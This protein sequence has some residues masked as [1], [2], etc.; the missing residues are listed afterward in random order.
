MRGAA[1]AIPAGMKT[2]AVVLAVVAAGCSTDTDPWFGI[3][4]HVS[5]PNVTHV[6]AS[7]PSHRAIQKVATR[8][9]ANGNF[10]FDLDP[11]YAWVVSFVDANQVG[12][13]MLVGSLQIGSLDALV[14]RG[15]GSLDLG[16]VTVGRGR[17]RSTTAWADVIA[18]LGI[19]DAT[20][21]R[22][23]AAD[24]LA[25]RYANPD[26]DNDGTIDALERDADFRVDLFG[27][28][29]LT[30]DG[31]DATLDDLV[32]APSGAVGVH[33]LQTGIVVSIPR[34]YGADLTSARMTFDGDF[35]GTSLGD[36]TPVVPAGTPVTQPEVLLGNVDGYP[37]IGV[38]ARAGHDLPTGTY[39]V[40]TTHH[41]FTFADVRPGGD[42][43]LGAGRNLVVPFLHIVPSVPGCA[44]DCFLDSI[45]YTW[46][47]STVD[48]W[49]PAEAG[50]LVHTAH[51]D[52]VRDYAG[53]RQAFRAE[54]APVPTATIPWRTMQT[55]GMTPAQLAG[56]TTGQLCYVSVT[57]DDQVGM[58]VTSRIANPACDLQ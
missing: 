17:A 33:Y 7:T 37:T 20:A 43:Q 3:S 56:V 24:D 49:V 2:L 8:V 39:T 55:D 41:A 6:V 42:A 15:P 50:E 58:R 13:A 28:L 14:P 19:D 25:T 21:E 10:A 16:E 11:G 44:A 46:M 5:A 34:T 31:R 30:V 27:S 1:V 9:D 53:A 52:I 40:T 38:F 51:L 22:L 36:A 18:A 32:R 57:Y 26:I 4:G 23:G 48:G 47:R 35:Y 12:E 54:L 45:E 29:G